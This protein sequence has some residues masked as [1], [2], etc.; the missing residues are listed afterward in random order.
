MRATS[1]TPV[2]ELAE[3][4]VIRQRIFT[5]D[6]PSLKDTAACFGLDTLGRT[7]TSVLDAIA[8]EVAQAPGDAFRPQADDIDGSDVWSAGEILAHLGEMELAALPFWERVCG[9]SLVD[10]PAELIESFEQPPATRAGC[11]ALLELIDRHSRG[12]VRHVLASCEGDETAMHFVLGHT[13]VGAAIL[14]TS[15]HLLDHL[16]QLRALGNTSSRT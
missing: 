13:T 3:L 12:I 9:G 15:I 16:L 6:E 5:S 10:P 1:R 4:E 7:M 8:A 14:G 2:I 11:L